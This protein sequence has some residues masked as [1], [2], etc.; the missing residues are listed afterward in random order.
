MA[1]KENEL[2]KNVTKHVKVEVIGQRIYL[3]EY[4]VIVELELIRLTIIQ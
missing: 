3:N 4:L 1:R 2:Y